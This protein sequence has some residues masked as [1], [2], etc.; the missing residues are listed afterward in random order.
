M[1]LRPLS[2]QVRRF[3]VVLL[4]SNS[5]ISLA[6]RLMTDMLD[7]RWSSHL[8][9]LVCLVRQIHYGSV[10]QPHLMERWMEAENGDK[11]L[12]CWPWNHSPRVALA[13]SKPG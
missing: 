8:T 3:V 12:S 9:L 13:I 7:F 11:E 6:W 2:N 4:S 10:L 5:I 1:I